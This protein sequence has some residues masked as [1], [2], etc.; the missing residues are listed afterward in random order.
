MNDYILYTSQHIIENQAQLISDIDI[1]YENF[2]KFFPNADSTWTY[3]KYNIFSLT[4]GSTNFYVLFQELRDLIRDR[5]GSADN[6]WM[7]SWVN[8]LTYD[9]LNIL[10]W[11]DHLFNYHGYISI[12]PKNTVTI[13]KDYEIKNTVG[14]IYIGPGYRHHKVCALDEYSGER[15]TIGFDLVLQQKS[16]NPHVKYVNVPLDN[17]S[18]IPLL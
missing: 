10:D 16:S 2:K 18:F 4:A 15:I 13:F 11:H 7:Q 12:D 1:A 14:Q 17:L 9:E 8:Y 5:W 6:I 3:N